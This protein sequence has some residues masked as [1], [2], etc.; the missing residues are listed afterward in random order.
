MRPLPYVTTSGGDVKAKILA[1]VH[2]RL[3]QGGDLATLIVF[4]FTLANKL[5]LHIETASIG[6]E[7]DTIPKDS[8]SKLELCGFSPHE[9]TQLKLPGDDDGTASSQGEKDL[10]S[11]VGMAL[12]DSNGNP[13]RMRWKI[14]TNEMKRRGLPRWYIVAILLRRNTIDDFQASFYIKMTGQLRGRLAKLASPSMEGDPIIFSPELQGFG[15]DDFG[16]DAQKLADFPMHKISYGGIEDVPEVREAQNG[17]FIELWSFERN[18]PVITP[19]PSNHPDLTKN[20]PEYTGV[21]CAPLKSMPK[22]HLLDEYFAYFKK[23]EQHITQEI[24][25]KDETKVHNMYRMSLLAWTIPGDRDK[26]KTLNNQINFFDDDGLH[27]IC[28]FF[29]LRKGFNNSFITDEGVCSNVI[30]NGGNR[31]FLV[32]TPRSQTGYWSLILICNQRFTNGA[33][34]IQLGADTDISTALKRVHDEGSEDMHPLLLLHQ[35]FSAYH[36]ST[37]ASLKKVFDSVEK[38]DSA[39]MDEL[40][41]E[42]GSQPRQC[43]SD[44]TATQTWWQKL[45]SMVRF[46]PSKQSHKMTA[47]PYKFGALSHTLHKARM[48]LVELAKRSKFESEVSQK[49]RTSLS[50]NP[51]LASRVN[52]VIE[53]ANR[54]GRDIDNLPDRIASQTDVLYSLIAQRDA[55]LQYI[56]AKETVKDSKAMKTLAVITI[57]FLPGTFVAAIFS[58]DMGP[59]SKDRQVPIFAAVVVPVTFL[60]MVVWISWIKKNPYGSSSTDIEREGGGPSIQGLKGSKQP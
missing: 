42:T 7:F 43:P 58:T 55:K 36:D 10:G 48:E 49:L 21:P 1:C 18:G 37:I 59:T 34:I 2:G 26:A 44:E 17:F 41:Y 22:E 35:L 32:Q 51:D 24:N 46:I 8:G 15:G 54:H 27:T 56:L 39:I 19:R 5:N 38:V 16:I 9:K 6:L 53:S 13:T 57:V 50:D 14:T 60:L 33:A 25:R 29:K 47:Q 23:N 52:M 3:K 20:T 40:K 31:A 4:R 30:S 11:I 12:D 45:A 28:D